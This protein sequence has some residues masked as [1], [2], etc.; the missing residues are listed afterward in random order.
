MLPTVFAFRPLFY[1][2][3]IL[4]N[5][6]SATVVAADEPDVDAW[7]ED[8]EVYARML[9]E[10][11]I[12]LF[13]SLPEAAFDQE[14]ARISATLPQQSTNEILVDLMT[15][16]ASIGDGHTS[17]PLWSASLARFPIELKRLDQGLFVVGTTVEYKDLLGSELVSINE[18]SAEALYQRFSALAPFSENPYSTA[19]RAARYL[20][21]AELLDGLGVIDDL[22]SANFTFSV[23]D[24]RST[25]VIQSERDPMFTEVLTYRDEDAFDIEERI[26][27]DFWFAASKDRNGVYLKFRRYPPQ[28]KVESLSEDLLA[29]INEHGTQKLVIDLRDNY[30]G[31]FFLGLL[32]AR[33]LVLA[34]SIDWKSGV[35][36]LIDNVTFSAAMSNAAQYAQL[37]NARLVGEPTGAVPSGYQD[38]GQ[39][40]LPN[41]KLEITFSK[42]LYHF[43]E[44]GK[45]ALYPDKLITHTIADYVPGTDR[46]LAWVLER[47]GWN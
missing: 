39:F 37:L 7:R 43:K 44:D 31:D 45:D 27:D 41:S 13:H 20:P 12:D 15:L 42:R 9:R 3:L 2:A 24:T 21:V 34:D 38:M 28:R 36:V 22:A 23:G 14:L 29:F 1:A 6:L 30:G 19:V 26:D 46:Q 35:F 25:R 33:Y 32:L 8:L 18:T 5:L 11:H 47:I 4:L 10:N 16:T 17:L 40:T